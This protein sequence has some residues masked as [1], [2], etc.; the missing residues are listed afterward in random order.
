MPLGGVMS[1]IMSVRKLHTLAW[2]GARRLSTNI[3]AAETIVE[4]IVSNY[5]D[6]APIDVAFI[7]PVNDNEK[8]EWYLKV[9]EH[10]GITN[11]AS[12][13]WESKICIL[14]I[15]KSLGVDDLD[16]AVS[17]ATLS[18]INA[19]QRADALEHSQGY[20][21]GFQ[22]PYSDPYYGPRIWREDVGPRTY[23][24]RR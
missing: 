16:K 18:F 12:I 15:C 9:L 20:G 3:S 2:L 5:V 4:K 13:D 6:H 14:R 1:V 8:P 17:D 22:G 21:C 24:R 19:L 10:S 23:G 7:Y 11:W